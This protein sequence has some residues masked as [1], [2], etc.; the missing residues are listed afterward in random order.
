MSSS[1]KAALRQAVQ[2]PAWQQNLFIPALALLT[3]LWIWLE[4]GRV[5]DVE[6]LQTLWR[7]VHEP[8]NLF[9]CLLVP[10]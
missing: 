1:F 10:L 4:G 7:S 5:L 8:Q 9:E 6:S 3:A 2:C